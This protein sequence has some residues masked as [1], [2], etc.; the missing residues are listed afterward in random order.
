M[1]L[2]AFSFS[3]HKSGRGDS[4][5]SSPGSPLQNSSRSGPSTLKTAS[6]KKAPSK[7]EPQDSGVSSF[8][9]SRPSRNP[10]LANPSETGVMRPQIAQQAQNHPSFYG[11]LVGMVNN[12]LLRAGIGISP[13]SHQS[14]LNNLQQVH[15]GTMSQGTAHFLEAA[16]F[17]Q[18]SFQSFKHGRPLQGTVEASGVVLNTVGGT[19]MSVLQGL[20]RVSQGPTPAELSGIDPW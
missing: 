20:G 11:T 5:S 7:P 10:H 3:S 9:P 6:E 4:S 15:A 17:A 8:T 2:K 1:K 12:G 19:G 14:V 16:S 13:S 18:D